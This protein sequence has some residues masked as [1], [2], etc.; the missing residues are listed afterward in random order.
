[1]PPLQQ[2]HKPEINFLIILLDFDQTMFGEEKM[3][4]WQ[5]ILLENV[6]KPGERKLTALVCFIVF[7][8]FFFKANLHLLKKDINQLYK[9]SDI[10]STVKT[11]C[12]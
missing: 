5:M 4:S 9:Y 11:Q 12:F 6:G 2:S 3:F 10:I 7:F 1:M 8:C